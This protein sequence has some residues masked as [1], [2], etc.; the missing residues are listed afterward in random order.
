[1]SRQC[2]KSAIKNLRV[3]GRVGREAAE[4]CS[5]FSCCFWQHRNASYGLSATRA[6]SFDPRSPLLFGAMQ[7]WWQERVLETWYPPVKWFSSLQGPKFWS[8]WF[9][10]PVYRPSPLLN[11]GLQCVWRSSATALRPAAV[12]VGSR[13]LEMRRAR[14]VSV[15][16][17]IAA[18]CFWW[19]ARPLCL[20][21]LLMEK[22]KDSM[23]LRGPCWALPDWDW[24]LS[25]MTCSENQVPEAPSPFNFILLWL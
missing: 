14:S 2:K 18:F 12:Q 25:S 22:V 19:G 7:S 17:G 16:L 24:L 4:K 6:P 13:L 21:C 8:F 9:T 15:A 1:M 10:S 20:P 23:S 5:S 3:G 11:V